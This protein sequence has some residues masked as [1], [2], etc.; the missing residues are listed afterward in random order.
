MPGFN[1]VSNLAIGGKEFAQKSRP[2]YLIAHVLE[3]VFSPILSLQQGFEM[4]W[5][6]QGQQR[7]V[8]PRV[9]SEMYEKLVTS[10]LLAS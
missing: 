7:V 1:H 6:M 10:H 9:K 3:T 2:K 5:V 4:P 8:K